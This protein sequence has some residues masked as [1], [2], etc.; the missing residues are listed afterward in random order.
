MKRL[1]LIASLGAALALTA[2]AAAFHHV[3]LPLAAQ[4]C[5]D[6]NEIAGVNPTAR[7]ALRA[8]GLTLPLAPART[9]AE[10]LDSPGVDNCAAQQ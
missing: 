8:A 6:P 3:A 2:P 1:L 4:E 7:D 9:P 5:A 10:D